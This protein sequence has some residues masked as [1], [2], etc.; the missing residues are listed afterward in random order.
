MR[1]VRRL[2]GFTRQYR[3]WMVL[4][5]LC[6]LCSSG[7]ALA[8]P[9]VVKRLI[10]QGIEV[11]RADMVLCYSLSLLGL[12]L[13]KSGAAFVQTYYTEFT[14]L[15]VVYNIRNVL[16]DHIQH[17]SFTYHDEA[18]TG[19]L[20]S[21]S[22]SDVDALRGF[23]GGGLQNLMSNS[24]IFLGVLPIC[25]RMDWRLALVALAAL[26]F[27]GVVVFR[28]SAKINPLY[29]AHQNQMGEMTNTIQQNLMGIRVVKAF[30]REDHEVRRFTVEVRKALDRWMGYGRVSAF[31]T[32]LMDFIAAV[33]TTSVLLYGGI[34]V[35]QG[36]LTV[37]EFI[38]FNAYLGM[39]IWPVRT[40]AGVVEMAQSA[41]ASAD[42]IFEILD[43]RPEAHLGDGTVELRDCQG[44][45]EFDDV[46]FAY[47]DGSRALA[48]ISFKVQPGEMVALVG[49]TGSGKSSLV[50]LLPRFYDVTGGRLLIDG[51]D[52]KDYTLTSLRKQIGIV[53]QETFLFGDSARGNIAYARPDAS[54]DEVVEA[55]KAANIH[56]FIESL[57]E[58]YDTE[59]G[60]R[61]VNLSGG[62]KQ[63]IAIA[64]ALLMDPPILI[65]DDSTSS[66][67]TETEMLIQKTLKS[68][69]ASRTTFVIAQRLSTVKRADKIVVLE[70][71]RVADLGTHEALL[72]KEGLYAEICRLQ[73]IDGAKSAVIAPAGIMENRSCQESTR[74]KI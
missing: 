21:R 48:N 4:T 37:G 7:I 3:H 20:I 28:F 46:S 45:V 14:A 9:L 16:F 15:R 27:L 64:R 30:A 58:G 40:L 11:G 71:G 44:A 73:L 19:Q 51:I 59:I 24:V 8:M 67:D 72:V 36:H 69:T 57:P 6:A 35:I 1:T 22:T 41:I 65:M 74:T 32:P 10:D 50:N 56:R 38:A 2:L 42:R 54:L 43:T 23:M 70:K 17:L 29:A 39:L 68:L 61:G 62:Q 49:P 55:A 5:A 47:A 66:V 18:E 63:R 13:A 26:P 12:V 53:A 25:F 33:G 60:E 52:V 34:Q 31:Y